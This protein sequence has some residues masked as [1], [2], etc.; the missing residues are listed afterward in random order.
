[1]GFRVEA[2][3]VCPPVKRISSLIF[4]S[5]RPIEYSFA[6]GKSIRT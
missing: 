2:S 5:A 4:S 6:F 3:I 1:L